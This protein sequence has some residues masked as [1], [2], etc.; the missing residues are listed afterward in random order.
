MPFFVYYC[1]LCTSSITVSDASQYQAVILLYE[2]HGLAR[3]RV[4]V[5]GSTVLLVCALTFP[6]SHHV[7]SS[8]WPCKLGFCY[9]GFVSV[10]LE[11][12][13]SAPFLQKPLASPSPLTSLLF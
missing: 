3:L 10:L 9:S 2:E 8:L 5:A 1:C 13:Q 6:G 11:V 7:S 12:L 4:S